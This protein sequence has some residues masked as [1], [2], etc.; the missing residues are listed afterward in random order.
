MRS[1]LRMAAISQQITPEEVLPLLARN[2]VMSGYVVGRPTQ[3]LVLLN[4]YL[5]QARE[6]EALAG[7]GEVLQVTNCEDAKPLLAI[8][9]YRLQ[10]SCGPDAALE[11]ADANRAFLTVNSGFPL[12]DLE[13]SLREGKPFETPYAPTKV[14][15]LYK[16][17][18]W[19]PSK[20]NSNRGVV[21]A[22][23]RDPNLARLYWAMSRMDSETSQFLWQSLGLKKLILVAPV[24]DFYGSQISVRSGRVLVP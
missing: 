4:W 21:D 8:L 3:F 7:R 23:L 9:G 17:S 11:T 19:V 14:P 24:M 10:K 2:V 5:D 22:I 20:K 6:L 13:D 15:I 16:T 18:D 12:A 1:F